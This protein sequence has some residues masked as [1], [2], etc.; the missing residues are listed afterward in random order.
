MSRALDWLYRHEFPSWG[1]PWNGGRIQFRGDRMQ[2]ITIPP[3]DSA[4]QVEVDRL[5]TALQQEP[6]VQTEAE[7]DARVAHLYGLT[8][9]EYRTILTDTNT[10]D[11]FQSLAL[12][13]FTRIAPDS[14]AS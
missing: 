5:V 9:S 14:G 8:E 3:A 1:D 6:I 11:D 7:L 10:P 4:T 13:W 2:A 12:E